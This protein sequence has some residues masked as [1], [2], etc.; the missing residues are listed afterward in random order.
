MDVIFDLGAQAVHGNRQGVIIDEIPAAIP[1]PFQQDLAGEDLSRMAG[2]L[3]QQLIFIGSDRQ[4]FPFSDCREGLEIKAQK[5][6]V[7]T[8][9]LRLC[10]PPAQSHIHPAFQYL[11]MKRLGNVM[12]CPI[13]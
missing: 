2:Q 10:A 5:A 13:V 9:L 12:V 6:I 11:D 7:K 3:P 8:V 1:Q 4:P